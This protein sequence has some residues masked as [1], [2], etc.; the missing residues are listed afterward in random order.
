MRNFIIEKIELRELDFI[1]I[2]VILMNVCSELYLCFF[3]KRISFDFEV[4]DFMVLEEV[5]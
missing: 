1:L 3:K 4:G 2:E 5:K